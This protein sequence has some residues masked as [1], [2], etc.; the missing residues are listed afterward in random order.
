MAISTFEELLIWQKAKTLSLLVYKKF[1][2]VRD[3]GF[4]DQIQRASI[5]VMNNIAEGFEQHNNKQFIRY[6]LIAKGSLAEVRSM[7]SMAFELAYIDKKS[8]EEI[9][10]LIIETKRMT[11]SMI[12]KLRQI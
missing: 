6:L 8:Y 11:S 3:F 9:L 7:N 4:K 10:S 2:T 12:T 5:S 1:S